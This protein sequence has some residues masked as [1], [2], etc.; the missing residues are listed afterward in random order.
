MQP[1]TFARIHQ[2]ISMSVPMLWTRQNDVIGSLGLAVNASLERDGH[3]EE[4]ERTASSSRR[5]TSSGRRAAGSRAVNAWSRSAA[6]SS[7]STSPI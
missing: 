2:Y 6:R 4:S 1:L 5:R 3:E 7:S